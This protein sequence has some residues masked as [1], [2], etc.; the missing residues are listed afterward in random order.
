MIRRKK[1]VAEETVTQVKLDVHDLME[2]YKA[3]YLDGYMKGASIKNNTKNK[4]STWLKIKD[5]AFNS[6]K[7]SIVE[8]ANKHTQE[9]KGGAL[10]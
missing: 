2:M 9:L 6:F 8:P 10:K 3:G 5:L 1:A 7:T 4:V